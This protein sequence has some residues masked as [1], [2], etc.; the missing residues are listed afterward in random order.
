MVSS[1]L[2]FCFCVFFPCVHLFTTVK[3]P[4]PTTLD[5]NST[6]ALSTSSSTAIAIVI[7]ASSSTSSPASNSGSK[8]ILL[9][10]I[11]VFVF[12]I[13]FCVVL[14]Y[15]YCECKLRNAAR[16]NLPRR[17]P[18]TRT[19]A[20]PT[21]EVAQNELIHHYYMNSMWTLFNEACRTYGTLFS[22][23]HISY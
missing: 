10:F 12:P 4:W 11:P 19:Y 22:A 3:L 15:A 14:L 21:T 13:L 2:L 23:P 17:G 6:P 18:E 20:V 8:N 16:A 9:F 7:T 5:R 1:T